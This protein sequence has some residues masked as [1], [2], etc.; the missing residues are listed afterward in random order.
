[1]PPLGKP[2]AL[3]TVRRGAIIELI[4]G[5][6]MVGLW[7]AQDTLAQWTSQT[8]VDGAWVILAFANWLVACVAM[9]AGIVANK[10]GFVVGNPPYP[11]LI[12]GHV[13]I[14]AGPIFAVAL[15]SFDL[16]FARH[17]I[18]VSIAA[19]LIVLAVTLA[20]SRRVA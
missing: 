4:L 15:M 13:I 8:V 10:Q 16:Q 6:I 9:L 7:L 17:I 5:A 1:M 18:P 11:K 20:L 3:M 14:A 19:G 2:I 12:L